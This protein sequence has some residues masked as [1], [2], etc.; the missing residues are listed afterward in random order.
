MG[1]IADAHSSFGAPAKQKD[2][3]M[4]IHGRRTDLSILS[5][6]SNLVEL[7]A[8]AVVIG[9][10]ISLAATGLSLRLDQSGTVQLWL[11]TLLTVGGCLYL[12][13]RVVP[14]VNKSFGFEGVLVVRKINN[15]V[16]PIDRYELAEHTARSIAA[17]TTENK[18][19]GR[20]WA[21]SSL[22]PLDITDRNAQHRASAAAKLAQEAVEYFVLHEFSLH[23]S[24]HFDNNPRVSDGEVQRIGRQD[25]PSVLLDNRFLELFSKPMDE[26]EAF[27]VQ[28]DQVNPPQEG[29]I[30]WAT[31]RGGAIFDRFELILPAGAVTSRIDSG[32]IQVRTERLSMQVA[33]DFE[34]WS[35]VL[36]RRF[37]ELYLNARFDDID[38]YTVNL[39]IDVKFAWWA[40]FTPAGWEYYRW[41]DSFVEKMS[42]AFSFEQFISDVGWHAVLTAHVIQH[43]ARTQASTPA[44]RPP[45]PSSD[46]SL[47]GE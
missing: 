27:M 21:N 41:L 32:S 12:V 19:L 46:A 34:G 43:P 8:V 11:G 6:R 44:S 24:E 3:G 7:V 35:A 15:E 22:K 25:I 28:S 14:K 31:G 39:H 45:E 33:V 36:P 20:A 37:G 26:R 13:R 5:I 18:A 9:F 2:S 30:V 16:V 40:L 38:S 42:K 1:N 10:G 23:L 17:L 4:N 29:T 47:D